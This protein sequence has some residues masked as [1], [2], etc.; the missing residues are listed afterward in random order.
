MQLIP[1][2]RAPPSSPTVER[3]AEPHRFTLTSLKAGW[4]LSRRD[5]HQADL[6]FAD[7]A[8][9][10]AFARNIAGGRA[11]DIELWV[12]GLYVFVQQTEG[13]PHRITGA[14]RQPSRW[15]RRR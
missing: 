15:R 1:L 7:L 2:H 8:G 5:G 11:A 4:S 3:P 12:D 13:W 6:L 14:A 9:A 10:L